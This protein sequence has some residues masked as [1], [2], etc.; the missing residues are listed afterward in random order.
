MLAVLAEAVLA[1]LVLNRALE[2]ERGAVEEEDRDRLRQQ[3]PARLADARAQMLDHLRVDLVHHPVDLL[4]GK[5]HAEV[6]LEPAHA[7]PLAVGVGDPCHHH[8][9]QRVV[10]GAVARARQQRI[11]AQQ[12]VHLAV[13][14]VDAR[15]QALLLLDLLEV[16]RELV[17]AVALA[18]DADHL[19][20]DLL[21]REQQ[22]LALVLQLRLDVLAE[23]PEAL[24]L[25]LV[26]GDA[27]VAGRCAGGPC[28]RRAR[29][30]RAGPSV[31]G[32]WAWS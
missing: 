8:V 30:R 6:L 19:L 26:H 7:A 1:Q 22:G 32:C 20:G 27:D 9:E 31:A 2:V 10:R 28:H 16:D 5:A 12:A 15:D 11:Q 3:R 18:S 24:E 21:G 17:L 13:D 4:E 14:L 25:V 23:L 29:P